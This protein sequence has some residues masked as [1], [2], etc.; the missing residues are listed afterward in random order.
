VYSFMNLE[1]IEIHEGRGRL[2]FRYFI[3]KTY[4]LSPEVKENHQKSK[5]SDL[6]S[7]GVCLFRLVFGTLPFK[8]KSSGEYAK[9]VKGG[10]ARKIPIDHASFPHV[11]PVQ[12][13]QY[14]NTLSHFIPA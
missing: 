3:Y 2:S 4:Y 12:M 1:N 8:S 7:T 11:M 10:V 5:E 9:S 6:F 13:Q 14:I